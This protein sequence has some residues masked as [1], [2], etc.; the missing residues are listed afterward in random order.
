MEGLSRASPLCSSS[1]GRALQSPALEARARRTAGRSS[2]RAPT[3]VR[4][5][6]AAVEAAQAYMPLGS[7]TRRLHVRPVAACAQ[8]Q[9]GL[10]WDPAKFE[11]SKLSVQREPAGISQQTRR[12]YTLTHNDMTGE[13]SLSVGSSFNWA[14]VSGWC[15]RCRPHYRLHLSPGRTHRGGSCCPGLRA[16]LRRAA[17]R[18]RCLHLGSIL[19]KWPHS[20]CSAHMAGGGGLL[21]RCP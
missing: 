15:V 7:V 17:V 11:P 5:T 20:I 1:S 9:C 19:R 3:P 16:W 13:L 6:A 21:R 18:P 12:R 8:V 10:A 4:C 2:Q 14:Q